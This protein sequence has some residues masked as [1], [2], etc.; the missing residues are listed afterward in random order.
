MRRLLGARRFSAPRAWWAPLLALQA[1][2]LVLVGVP[3]LY[4]RLLGGRQPDVVHYYAIANALI[5]G[6]VPYRDFML[7]Y[8]PFAVVAFL[9]PRLAVLPT[10]AFGAFLW[11]LLLQCV[12]MSTG[13]GVL[14]VR[15]TERWSFPLSP[16]RALQLYVVLV[17]L[18]LHLLP[19]RYDLFPALLT[20]FAFQAL[21]AG[22]PAGSGV[23]LGLGIATKL[24][25]GALLPVFACS[26]LARKKTGDLARFL[27]GCLGAVA[28]CLLF[29]AVECPASLLDPVHYHQARGFEVESVAAGFALLIRAAGLRPAGVVFNFGALHVD[30]AWLEPWRRALPL[31]AAGAF[32]AFTLHCHRV[33]RRGFLKNGAVSP[34]LAARLTAAAILLFIALNKVFSPQYVFWLLPFAPLLRPRAAA[35]VALIFLTTALVFPLAFSALLRME[36]WA[37]ALL[38]ARNLLV[39]AT[40]GSLLVEPDEASAD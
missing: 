7:E 24:Y 28:A 1:A 35:A 17:T 18:G 36:L 3:T 30:A 27:A 26:L 11:A 4:L 14:L 20:A 10:A 22:E 38:N 13:L 23:W 15:V 32:A 37:V 12:A 40:L 5:R 2:L 34:R 33:L 8:P 6:E 25:P 19:W 21:L 29:F 16:R 31:I 39:L 9:L